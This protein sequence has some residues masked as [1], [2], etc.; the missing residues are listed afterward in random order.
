MLQYNLGTGEYK[1][2]IVS[3]VQFN[4]YALGKCEAIMALGNGYMG[5]RSATEESY[6]GQVRNLFVAGTFNQF[7]EYEVTELPNAPDVVELDIWLNGE[8][9]SLEKGEIIHYRRDL[10]IKDAELVRHVIWENAR[11]EQ[12]EFM[13]RRF[14]SLKNL[15]LIGMKVEIKPLNCAANIHITSGINGQMT[16]SG[17]QHFHE[18]E[19]RIFDKTYLQ[20][21]Q[22]TTESKIDF[23]VNATHRYM[24]DGKEI[25]KEP[26]M[27]IDRRK[28]FIQVAFDVK[29]GETLTFEKLANVYTSRDKQ[30]DHDAYSLDVMRQDAL[31]DLKEEAK[32]GYDA[33]FSENVSEWKKRWEQMNITIES[34]N[35]FDQLAI[36]F[37]HYHLII[38][39]PA[40]DAR[41]GVAAKGLTG[42]GYKG[43]SFWDTEIFILPF[44]TYT[45]PHIARSLLEYRY[46]T[47]EGA[48]RKAKANGYE[49]AMYPWESAFTGDEVT[50]VW[51]AVDIVTGKATKIWSGFIEQHITSDIAFAVW[52]YYK[53]TGD[54][55]FMERYGYE[56]LFDTATFW[57]SRLE[58]NEEKQQYHIND[59]IGPDEYKEHVN[60]NAF[61]NYMA[62]WNIET[63]IRYY[64]RLKETNPALLDALHEKIGVHEAYKKWKEKVDLIYLPQPR[65]EDLVI[66]QDDTYL[67]KQIIDL[68]K[69]KKQTRV[70]TIFE[71]YNLE[72]VNNIQ[73]SKQADI[74]VLFYLLENKFSQEVK[75]ANWNYYE[76][77]TLH[78][79]SLSLSTHCILASDMDDRELAYALFEQA[80][81]ID[82]GPNMKSSDHGM[83]TAS[84]GGVWQSV[85]CGFGGVRML[86]GKLRIHPKL[87]KQ[88]TK[89]SFPIYWRGDRLE[90]TVTHEQLVVKKV[91][92]VHDAVT[93]D[94]F[95]TAYEVKDEITIP[96]A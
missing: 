3:E 13:F 2:W 1:N 11:G 39:T 5:L 12:F 72:Q 60:N 25:E 92:N 38:M 69:Y 87:P 50:P 53:I 32:K 85:V 37:A 51:G 90:V 93:F 48:R 86:D 49:G 57:A 71:D 80:A 96:L 40:H 17:A 23:V 83:H 6:V 95:G 19:K 35:E 89:L 14:V 58:W 75:R 77:K 59:V 27:A 61:T 30:Y 4:P 10:N 47:I 18:G 67:T 34:E 94:V 84:I 31:N 74:M 52:Q 33:L 70:G 73:V 9:F 8:K 21:I 42:E 43:H 88:W 79:S 46:N 29:Q 54:D 81:R 62:H 45:F 68:T 15:H 20:L 66:P 82:L 55:D 56:M 26:R 91:T 41:F 65:E 63:A 36:R 16:N 44:F 24:I 78:D 76:P 28:V 64:E 7:D 22:T